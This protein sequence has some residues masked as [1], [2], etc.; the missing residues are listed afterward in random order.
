MAQP[1]PAHERV[2]VALTAIQLPQKEI[3][4]LL[5]ISA[6]YLSH[7]K[8]GARP[9]AE[10][11]ALKIER[12][13][14]ISLGWLL[15]GLGSMIADH[16]R[17][18]EHVTFAT[19]YLVDGR[20]RADLVFWSKGQMH[21]VKFKEPGGMSGARRRHELQT[22][23]LALLT[24]PAGSCPPPAP[25]RT[26]ARVVLPCCAADGS[27]YCLAAR[28]EWSRFVRR[29]EVLLLEWRAPHEW[30]PDEVDGRICAAAIG[31]PSSPDLYHVSI[32]QAEGS[33]RLR[34]LTE[35][36]S[37]EQVMDSPRVRALA[38]GV[39]ADEE[40][41]VMWWDEIRVSGVVLMAFRTEFSKTGRGAGWGVASSA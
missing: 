30:R 18:R 41:S 39:D 28:P 40:T 4:R 35:D 11:L 22:A 17:A 32:E 38:G 34:L 36:L 3:A 20:V 29:D 10:S 14:G 31:E 5:D 15:T 2:A 33:P 24:E 12:T 25:G 26:G 37:L 21:V 19:E 9:L 27:F 13:F 23:T 7:V 1:S 8:S 6:A 16:E